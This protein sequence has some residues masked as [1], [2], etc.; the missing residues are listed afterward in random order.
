M[1][2][3]SCSLCKEKILYVKGTGSVLCPSEICPYWK[4]QCVDFISYYHVLLVIV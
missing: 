4:R 3:R 2:P 1:R